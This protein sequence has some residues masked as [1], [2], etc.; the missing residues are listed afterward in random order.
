MSLETGVS[1]WHR[2]PWYC[3]GRQP[4]MNSDRLFNEL[5]AVAR[6]LDVEVRLEPFSTAAT[7]GGGLC[8][9]GGHALILIDQH[10]PLSIRVEILARALARLD[11]DPV[12]MTPEARD[13]LAAVHHRAPVTSATVAHGTPPEGS[14]H[15]TERVRKIALGVAR[16][17]ARAAVRV[18]P[19]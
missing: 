18:R 5:V 19:P 3:V 15:L 11:T 8:M 7:S 10:A 9:L 17:G 2:R 1:C 12:Y 4:T 13:L 6:K 16:G 14:T